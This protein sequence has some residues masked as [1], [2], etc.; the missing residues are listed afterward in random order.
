MDPNSLLLSTDTPLDKIVVL[1]SGSFAVPTGSFLEINVAHGLSFRPLIICTWSTTP[2]FAVSYSA[3]LS[4]YTDESTPQLIAQSTSTNFRFIPQNQTG[5]D[6]TYYWRIFAYMPSDV[7]V[8]AAF[9]AAL[10]DN[11]T[12]STDYNYSK[13]FLQGI[14]LWVSGSKVVNHGLGYRPQ[15]EV[16]F[17][18]ELNAGLLTHWS[19]GTPADYTGSDGVI[20]TDTQLIFNFRSSGGVAGRKWYYIIYADTAVGV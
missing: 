3:G 7:N 6:L 15:V 10:A 9:T 14:E 17:E 8:D 20:V 19:Q 13:V 11:Y 18:Q 16:W 12:I 5:T 2:S 1:A 4:G